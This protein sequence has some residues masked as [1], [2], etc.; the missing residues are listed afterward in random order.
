MEQ[1]KNSASTTLNGGINNSTTSVT[2]TDGSV[3]PSSGD[4]RVLVDSEIMVCTSRSSNTLT[5][6][7]GAE[8]TSAASHS[9]GVGVEH[10][11]TK[12][13]F[14]KILNDYFQVGG[15][16]SRP[17]TPRKGTIYQ[18]TDLCHARWLYDA[19]NWNLIHPVCVPYAERMDFSSWTALNQSGSTFTDKNG[20]HH[21]S[22]PFTNDV[23]GWYKALPTAP[24]KLTLCYD[25][26]PYRENTRT[27]VFLG[28]RLNSNG[29]LRIMAHAASNTNTN[30]FCYE[31]WTNATTIN[32]NIVAAKLG[33]YGR[34]WMRFEDDNT[35]WNL[36]YSKDGMNFT[37][38]YSET[39]N[40]GITADKVFIGVRFASTISSGVSP[41]PNGN[42][43]LLGYKES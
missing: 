21:I 15:Y 31:D 24:Y 26:V 32:A 3:F 13:S 30:Q 33:H 41:A 18:A 19:T 2:V 22:R 8:G 9:S 35:N 29:K 14:E 12:G 11:Y 25:Y 43:F 6:T 39:R 16:A 17:A 42:L 23:A 1:L 4:F 10:L 27:Q 20:I 36:S 37:P 5:V 40:T 28:V 34:G 7:R 38:F